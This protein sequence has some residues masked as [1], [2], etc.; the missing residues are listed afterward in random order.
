VLAK[1]K[2]GLNGTVGHLAVARMAEG[3]LSTSKLSRD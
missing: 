1:R 2:C 3:P